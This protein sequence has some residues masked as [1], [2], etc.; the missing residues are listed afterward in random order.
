MPARFPQ[1]GLRTAGHLEELPFDD[2]LAVVPGHVRM[3]S[4]FLVITAENG[5]VYLYPDTS[6]I[7]GSSKSYE[8]VPVS[9]SETRT[10]S[11]KDVTKKCPVST[12]VNVPARRPCP[13]PTSPHTSSVTT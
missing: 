4:S 8:Y 3:R 11:S 2:R 5:L 1:L 10:P 9:T 13:P 7:E 12:S 6:G